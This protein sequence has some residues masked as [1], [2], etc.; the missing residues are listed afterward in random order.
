MVDNPLSTIFAFIGSFY[1]LIV[2]L[3]IMTLV[4]LLFFAG[5]ASPGAKPRSVGEAIV[6]YLLHAASVLLMTIGA[7]PTV[8]SVFAGIAYTGRTYIALLLV[9]AVGGML[10]LIQDQAARGID[11]ASRA[12]VE[13]IYMTTLKLIGYVVTLLATLSLLLSIV[14]LSFQPGWWVAPF[15]YLLFGLLLSWCIKDHNDLTFFKNIS[16]ATVASKA[17]KPAKTK[18]R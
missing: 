6:C 12:V 8:F 17:L 10:F 16:V 1:G 5:L 18:R 14:L 11:S 3:L 9:F 7:L 2:P 4:T 15:T 13:A